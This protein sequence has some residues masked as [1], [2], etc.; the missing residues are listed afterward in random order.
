MSRFLWAAIAAGVAVLLFIALFLTSSG[1][2]MFAAARRG[3]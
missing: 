1:I 2:S 3:R